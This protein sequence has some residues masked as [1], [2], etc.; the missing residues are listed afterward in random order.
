MAKIKALVPNQ[1]MAEYMYRI[2]EEEQIDDCTVE[3]IQTAESVQA[4]RKAIEDGASVIIARGLQAAM[5]K[6]Y[7]K[8]PLVEMKLTAQ[9]MGLM[10]QKAKKLS[11]QESP[12]IAFLG[13]MSMFP[14]TSYM[15]EIFGVRMKIYP[16]ED[17]SMIEGL[18][19]QDWNSRESMLESA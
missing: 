11:G 17:F 13:H 12:Q 15:N 16:I 9:E 7:T 18:V 8:V 4:A 3:V 19:E 10:I 1:K 5:I 2:M 14:D 6:E